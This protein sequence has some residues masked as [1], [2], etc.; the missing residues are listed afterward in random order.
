MRRC[1][2][3]IIFTL[4]LTLILAASSAHATTCP[5]GIEALQKES[6]ALCAN[7]KAADKAKNPSAR[8]SEEDTRELISCL[9]PFADSTNELNHDR[10]LAYMELS[11]L[12]GY[13]MND[14]SSSI[15]NKKTSGTASWQ[16]IKEAIALD[17]QSETSYDLLANGIIG[18]RKHSGFDKLFIQNYLHI[19]LDDE[20]KNCS[21]KMESMP[22]TPSGQ[23]ILNQLNQS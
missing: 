18:M 10:S 22:L 16:D 15:G 21:E 1:L 17:P 19:N 3:S 4:I 9:Q 13:V 14:Y 2:S 11:A 8:P 7:F 5:T 23:Q 6:D 12:W 20:K